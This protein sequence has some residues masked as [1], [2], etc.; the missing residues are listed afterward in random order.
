MKVNSKNEYSAYNH[1]AEFPQFACMR[2]LTMLEPSYNL[3]LA[4]TAAYIL[5]FMCVLG[6]N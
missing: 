2:M 1:V 6:L 4:G 5:Y 3:V